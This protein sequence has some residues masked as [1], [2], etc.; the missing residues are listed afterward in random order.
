[1]DTNEVFAKRQEEIDAL[2]SSIARKEKRLNELKP[3]VQEYNLAMQERKIL[4]KT[5]AGLQREAKIVAQWLKGTT[6]IDERFPLFASAKEHTESTET[7]T[8]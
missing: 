2:Q 7:T 1:M 4:R 6:I 8:P 3:I 5:L